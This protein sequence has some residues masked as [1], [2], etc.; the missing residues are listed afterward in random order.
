VYDVQFGDE[1]HRLNNYQAINL[2]QG[3]ATNPSS[4]GKFVVAETQAQRVAEAKAAQEA[5][6]EGRKQENAVALEKV[7]IGGRMDADAA[8]AA[9][10]ATEGEKNRGSALEIAKVRAA[11]QGGGMTPLQVFNAEGKIGKEQQTAL[12]NFDKNFVTDPGA[13]EAINAQQDKLAKHG[14]YREGRVL[15]PSTWGGPSRDEFRQPATDQVKQERRA[16]IISEYDAQRQR[17]RDIANGSPGGQQAPQTLL[18][19]PLQGARPPA[20]RT[21]A[22][23][24]ELPDDLVNAA[25]AEAAAQGIRVTPEQVRAM[26]ARK[27]GMVGGR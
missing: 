23:P 5:A 20:A 27:A 8:A 3:V 19:Q 24:G 26:A 11:A 25:V 10:R 17:L 13:A 21:T 4:F 9:A 18:Q 2:L 22:P 6:K 12:A 7:K 16:A 14:G 1:V 15:D